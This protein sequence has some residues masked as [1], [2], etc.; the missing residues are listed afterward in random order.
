MEHRGPDASG[1][2]NS[3][4]VSFSHRRLSIIDLN[5]NSNQPMH[6]TCENITIVYN[7]E[8]YNHSELRKILEKKYSFKTTNSDT[9]VIINAYKEWGIKCL[10]KFV[11][12]FAIAIY[13]KHT[14][15]VYLVRD[16]LGK[17]PLYYTIVNGTLFFASENQSFFKSNLLKKEI[18]DESIYHYLSFLTTPAPQTFF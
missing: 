15:K 6:S 18:D 4:H 2:F 14:K 17:K 7:G 3:K 5:E 1:F 10:D 12:M 9:E 16:R 11:G 13:D 8:I